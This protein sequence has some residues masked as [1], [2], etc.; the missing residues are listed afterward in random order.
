[1]SPKKATLSEPIPVHET[2]VYKLFSDNDGN[3][4]TVSAD[5]TAKHLVH[6]DGWKPHP[7]FV[8][9]VV[10]HEKGGWVIPA[11]RD[12]EIE[13]WDRSMGDLHRIFS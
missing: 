9:D 13:V 8:R 12:E 1:M 5:K 4:W 10:V 11:C 7:D 3:L 2:S 6:K